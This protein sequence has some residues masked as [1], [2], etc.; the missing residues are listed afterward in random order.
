M[1]VSAAV[2]ASIPA[3]TMCAAVAKDQSAG[4]TMTVL[5]STLR[6]VR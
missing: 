6:V 1:A 3:R 5:P 4:S 2:V